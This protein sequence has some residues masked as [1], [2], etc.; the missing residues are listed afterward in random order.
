MRALA[1]ALRQVRLE[2]RAFWRNPAAAF[3]TVVFPLAFMVIAQVAL[4]EPLGGS[5]QAARFYTPAIMAFGLITACY[6]NVAMGVVLARE[7]GILKR[8]RGTPLPTWAYVA[9]RAGYAVVLA[10]LLVIVVGA[11]E[12]SV[13]GVVPAIS[14]LP[15]LCLALVVGAASFAALGVAV[16]RLV[17]DAGAAP[18]V[19]NATIL[20]LLL[21]SDVLVP[22]DEGPL[23][24]IARLFPVRHLADALAA[25]YDPA[26][27]GTGLAAGSLVVVA[28]WG[29]AGLVA[30]LGAFSWEPRS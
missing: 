5:T 3:F 20:P 8:L 21:I 9:G 28:A 18:A 16:T 2:H 27:V 19:I 17:P 30:A 1:L 25:A 23:A 12:A 4:A 10:T 14:R 7:A 24:T 26:P 29:V 22:L 15:G 6:T 11:F 13:F